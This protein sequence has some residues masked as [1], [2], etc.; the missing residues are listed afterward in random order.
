MVS[1]AELFLIAGLDLLVIVLGI[2]FY[3]QF[4]AVSF[5]EEFS[6]VRGMRTRFYYLLLLLLTALTVVLLTTIVGIVMVIALLTLPPAV[7]S[8]FS[9][10]LWQTMLIAGFVTAVF[11]LAGMM[12]S[13][14]ADTP[15]GSTIIIFAGAVYLLFILFKGVMKLVKRK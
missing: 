10:N 7:A 12:I 1:R 11:T 9:K 2:L 3:H 8:L 4:L 14:S 5:D 15:S 13:Y 6:R